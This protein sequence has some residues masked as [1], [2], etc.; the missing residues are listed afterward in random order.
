MWFIMLVN[1]FVEAFR[2]VYEWKVAQWKELVACYQGYLTA[3][4]ESAEMLEAWMFGKVYKLSIQSRADIRES[5]VLRIW[6]IEYRVK[7]IA[8]RQWG[9]LV[10]TTV[11]LEKW[12]V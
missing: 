5:D 11:I 2:L 1:C 3:V 7:W 8:F 6:N 12:W 4:S 10:L 9:N